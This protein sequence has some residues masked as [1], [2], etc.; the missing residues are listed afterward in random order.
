MFCYHA[1][2]SRCQSSAHPSASLQSGDLGGFVD[3]RAADAK[4]HELEGDAG[5]T[6]SGIHQET[7]L[8]VKGRA[9]IDAADGRGASGESMSGL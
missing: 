7:G 2:F 9:A 6:L 4:E 1:H 5:L 3:G 8:Q